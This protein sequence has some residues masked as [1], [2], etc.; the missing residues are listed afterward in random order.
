MKIRV[1]R[2]RVKWAV[3]VLGRREHERDRGVGAV[4]VLYA[5]SGGR[6]L[7]RLALGVRPVLGG[8]PAVR[9]MAP[10]TEIPADGAGQADEEG[11]TPPGPKQIGWAVGNPHFIYPKRILTKK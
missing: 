8:G 1:T 6:V 5:D 4:P 11:D 2:A 9:Q 7:H 10:A 3:A